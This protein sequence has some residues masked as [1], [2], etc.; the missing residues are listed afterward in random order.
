[1]NFFGPS[2]EPNKLK[3]QLKLAVSRL[4][5]LKNKKANIVRDEKR[6][7]AELLKSNNEESARIR[8]E[9]IVRD[10]NLIECYQIIEILCELL[11]TRIQ[12]ISCS[13]QIPIE[14]KEAIFTLV[15]A[16]QRIQ[17]PELENIKIQLKAKY[18]KNLEHEV[19][20]QCGTHVN[21]KI[22][23]KLSYA[24]PDPAII[25]QYL[26]DIASHYKLDYCCQAPIIIPSPQTQFIIA[27]PDQAMMMQPQ[28]IIPQPI[29]Q[30][31]P[32]QS[33]QPLPLQPMQ[34]FPQQSQQPLP[35]QPGMPSF[36][37]MVIPQQPTVTQIQQQQQIQK[38]YQQPP[39]QYQPSAPPSTFN[40]SQFPSIP[41][42]NDNNNNN[43][44]NFNN[45]GDNF[46]SFP[47]NNFNNNSNNNFGGFPSPPPYQPSSNGGDTNYPDYD[48]LTARFEALKKSNGF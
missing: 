12:L 38:Q 1:M 46:P 40:V 20:C 25:F 32:Q 48:E 26:N 18:G 31:F 2:Y 9:T 19:N 35:Q 4:Q 22:V 37:V 16:S 36:P 29:T 24:T 17:I 30:N 10:D 3:V 39:P 23:Q 45:S 34:N 14:I 7:V 27:S 33:Q 11:H 21:P 47:N 13:D 5:I 44:N 28:P 41:T 42:H 43:N 8:V 15:Y 6:N